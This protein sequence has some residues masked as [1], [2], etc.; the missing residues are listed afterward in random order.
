MQY[1]IDIYLILLKML[2]L[3]TD[4][5]QQEIEYFL[6][7]INFIN[8]YIIVIIGIGIS[9]LL[10]GILYLW[11]INSKPDNQNFNACKK[12]NVKIY[13]QIMSHLTMIFIAIWIIDMTTPVPLHEK[14][15]RGEAHLLN[16]FAI[17]ML[18]LFIST[19]EMILLCQKVYHVF[20][21]PE[22]TI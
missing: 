16:A 17:A 21:D 6:N 13:R 5:Y 14:L 9:G 18:W 12:A 7:F 20:V 1:F 8:S 4:S 2:N 3:I 19:W 11:E 22:N 10:T 15:T